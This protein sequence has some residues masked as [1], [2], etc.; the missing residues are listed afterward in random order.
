MK[1]EPDMSELQDVI[2]ELKAEISRLQTV[3]S[4]TQQWSAG[5]I[6]DGDLITVVGEYEKAVE[7]VNP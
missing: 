6:L 1:G 4:A 5:R 3:V 7:A 2:T